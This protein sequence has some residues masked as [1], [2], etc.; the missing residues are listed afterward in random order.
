MGQHMDVGAA[1]V[2]HLSVKPNQ[3]IAVSHRHGIYSSKKAIMNQKG[4]G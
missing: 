3:P 1:P 2:H 4:A